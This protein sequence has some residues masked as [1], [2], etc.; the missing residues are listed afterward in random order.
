MTCPCF[1][2]I[3]EPMCPRVSLACPWAHMQATRVA[4]DWDIPL[5]PVPRKARLHVLTPQRSFRCWNWGCLQQR[6]WQDHMGTQPVLGLAHP[7]VMWAEGLHSPGSEVGGGPGPRPQQGHIMA[8]AQSSGLSL[9]RSMLAA[10]LH[11]L[12]CAL[13]T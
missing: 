1:I 8:D 10:R 12:P 5:V 4:W 9:Y 13:E 7:Q 11:W 6:L 3:W 2:Y